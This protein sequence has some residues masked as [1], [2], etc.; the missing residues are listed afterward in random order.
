MLNEFW[1]E[2]CY[3][4]KYWRDTILL[5]DIIVVIEIKQ[6][7][8]I[9]IFTK[10]KS[11]V[12]GKFILCFYFLQLESENNTFVYPSIFSVCKSVLFLLFLSVRHVHDW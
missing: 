12:F 1:N 4:P 11:V 7:D 8:F 9:S 10:G 2:Y 5:Q 6:P 3:L